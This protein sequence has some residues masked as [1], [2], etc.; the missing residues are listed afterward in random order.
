M[1]VDREC[2]EELNGVRLG[3]KRLERRAAR[4]LEKLAANP[5]ASLPQAMANEGELEAA[6]RLFDHPEVTPEKILRSHYDHTL[7]RIMMQPKGGVVLLVQDTTELDYTAAK[8]VMP[9]LGPLSHKNS[10]GLYAHPL[11]ALTP[12]GL[13]LGLVDVQMWTRAAEEFGKRDR[14]K[15]RSYEEKESVRWREG[16]ERTCALARLIPEQTFVCVSDAEADIYECLLAG[17]GASLPDRPP[18]AHF[19]I[20]SGQT[21]ALKGDESRLLRQGVAASP[22]L[23]T[24]DVKLQATPKRK[25]RTARLEVR[26]RRV[27][28]R[29]PPRVGVRLPPVAVNV[30][31]LEETNPPPGVEPICWVLLTSLPIDTLEQVL[32]IVD[33]YTARWGIEVFFRVLKTGCTVE[34]LQL[35]TWHRLQNCLALYLIVAWRVL[36]VMH[37]GRTCPNLP[38][39]ACFTDE[40]WRPVWQ[41]VLREPPPAQPPPLQEFI[42][43]LAQLGGYLPRA[44]APPPGPQVLWI[45]IRRMRDFAL[46]LEVCGPASTGY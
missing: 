19:L 2:A 21:R 15:E 18:Q 24:I 10:A 38:C 16:Y 20:R 11:L 41:I 35:E 7:M 29:P 31:L 46:A 32:R 3:D 1:W 40:E 28:L 17:E 14:R 33:Y 4:V 8:G 6:Y 27:L 39:T 37:L 25:A 43:V 36:Y 22:L 5:P 45:A 30:V 13:P 9:E 26:A 34:K 44:N 12:Q 42:L 23:T